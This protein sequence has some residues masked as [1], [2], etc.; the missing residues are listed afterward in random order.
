MITAQRHMPGSAKASSPVDTRLIPLAGAPGSN[1]LPWTLGFMTMLACLAMAAALS[2]SGLSERWAELARDRITVE[3]P[4]AS[5]TLSGGDTRAE[6]LQR[7][8]EALR[9]LAETA[10]IGS[11]RL[12]DEEEIRSDLGAWL[13]DSSLASDLPLPILLEADITAPGRADMAALESR[14]QAVA[15]GARVIAHRAL[16]GDLLRPAQ[17]AESMALAIMVASLLVSAALAAFSASAALAAHT[18]LI[19]ILHVMGADD[20]DI[21]REVQMHVLRRAL[22]GAAGGSS[23][24]FAMLFW[25][26]QSAGENWPTFLPDPGLSPID[27]PLLCLIPIGLILVTVFSARHTALAAL[28]SSA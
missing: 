20:S 14:L 27:L 28:H 16:A 6:N 3:L 19:A 8:R 11:P 4:P 23:I 25:I 2:L 9:L 1:Y 12:L 26:D 10:E 5:Q 21:A 15:P 22:I 7:T 24:A 13:G 18:E 17:L